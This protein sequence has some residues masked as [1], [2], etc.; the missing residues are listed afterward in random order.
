MNPHARFLRCTLAAAGLALL[1]AACSDQP[2]G[3]SPASPPAAAGGILSRSGQPQLIA[4][5]VKY[6]DH[7]AK[8]TTGRSGTATLTARALLGRDGTTALEVTT[9]ILDSATPAPGTLARVQVKQFDSDG[10][11][12]ATIVHNNLPG[13]GYAAFAYSGLG[14]GAKLAVLGNVRDIDPS[15]TDVVT[16]TGTVHW[17]PDLRVELHAAGRA[18]VGTPVNISAVV[19]EGNGDVG[20]RG[21]CVLHV[22]GAEVDR[23]DGIWVDAGDVVTCAF[24]HI[25]ETVG[26]K[27]LRVEVAGVVPGDFDLGNN[28]ANGSVQVMDPAAEKFSYYYAAV[29]DYTERSL[30]RDTNLWRGITGVNSDSWSEMET[31]AEVQ[32]SLIEAWIPRAVSFPLDQIQLSLAT[33]GATFF[34]ATLSELAVN[35]LQPVFGPDCLSRSVSGGSY[36]YVCT[37]GNAENG[38]TFVR[39]AWYAG[40]VTYQGRSYTRI[41]YSYGAPEEEYYSQNS[42][43]NLNG[44]QLVTIGPDYTFSIAVVDVDRTFSLSQTVAVGAPVHSIHTA[45]PPTG[46]WCSVSYYPEGVGHYC[47]NHQAERYMRFGQAWGVPD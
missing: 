20:A 16:L 24:T 11:H 18:A 17:R 2:F 32:E 8:P 46:E 28:S 23:A 19:A 27:Q 40:E 1:A 26:T 7:G 44:E 45:F 15:R 42:G 12:L 34:S 39:Y 9:G 6:S 5:S 41:W 10:D 36:L 30:L 47:V 21:D 35:E 29:W 22:D 37:F 33:N 31:D 13:G 25:F 38:A 4:N 14:R 3:A 43:T